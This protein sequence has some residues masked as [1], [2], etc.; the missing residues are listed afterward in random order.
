MTICLKNLRVNWQDL[1]KDEMNNTALMYSDIFIPVTRA[2]T[3]SKVSAFPL[4]DDN[5]Y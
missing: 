3:S 1:S 2:F 5:N 4:P